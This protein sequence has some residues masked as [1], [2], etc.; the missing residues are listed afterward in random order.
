MFKLLKNILSGT[1]NEGSQ[2]INKLAAYKTDIESIMGDYGGFVKKNPNGVQSKITPDDFLNPNLK[3]EELIEE[4][5]GK[6]VTSGGKTNLEV[7]D[8]FRTDVL[9][10]MKTDQFLTKEA[11]ETGLENL[12]ATGNM[13]ASPYNIAGQ[14]KGSE[15]T[16]FLSGTSSYGAIGL[17]GTAALAGGIN[18]A[19][20]GDFSTGAMV[21]LGAAGISR[22]LSKVYMDS[23]GSMEN[24][25]MKN[26]I[27]KSGVDTTTDTFAKQTRYGKLSTIKNISLDDSASEELKAEAKKFISQKGPNKIAKHNRAMTIGGGMLAGVAFTGRSDK[28]DYRRGFNSHRGNRV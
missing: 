18:T 11:M 12:Q 19:M 2:S 21:G 5:V 25:A 3:T 15:L 28:R 23:L 13:Y 24:V 7:M 16:D 22:G 17:L 6:I 20:G 26:L 1:A 14:T 10:N 9:E 4:N 27:S 8:A